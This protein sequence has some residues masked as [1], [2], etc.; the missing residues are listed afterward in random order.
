VVLEEPKRYDSAL[1]SSLKI[2]VLS[3]AYFLFYVQ[4]CCSEFRE[5][6]TE[7]EREIVC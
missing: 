4:I 3:F 2:M 5:W 1:S 7:R 6:Q